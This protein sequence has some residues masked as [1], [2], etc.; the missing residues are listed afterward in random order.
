[1]TKQLDPQRKEYLKRDFGQ[2]FPKDIGLIVLD[3][4]WGK[5]ET[6]L[7]IQP[8]HS[9]QDGFVH[10]GV[11]ATMADHTMGYA[12]YTVAPLNGRILTIEYKINYLRPAKGKQLYCLGQVVKPGKSV[13]P[14]RA[15]IFSR[16]QD[17][18]SM[19]CAVALGTMTSVPEEKL[20]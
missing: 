12:A 4:A 7:E 19:L 5:F 3:A 20:S 16:D 8:R 6:V 1:M 9:Q 18:E 2:G 11:L 13:I 17:R 14:C 10:A 15:E